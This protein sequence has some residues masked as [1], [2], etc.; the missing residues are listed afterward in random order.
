VDVP[1]VGAGV[2]EA[3]AMP[4]PPATAIAVPATA[5]STTRFMDFIRIL[6]LQVP[7][8]RVRAAGI[9]LSRL[10]ART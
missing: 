3:D 9:D 1:D 4:T 10:R 6:L 8:A 2:D 7:G 5:A